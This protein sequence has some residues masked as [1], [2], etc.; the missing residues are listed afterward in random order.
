VEEGLELPEE[1]LIADYRGRRVEY[2]AMVEKEKE[3]TRL[4][5]EAERWKDPTKVLT[6]AQR[7]AIAEAELN[8][9]VRREEEEKLP[10]EK[11]AE[12]ARIRAIEEEN[13]NL[14]EESEKRATAEKAS[15]AQ[16]DREHTV[17]VY[18][19]TLKL[20]GVADSDKSGQPINSVEAQLVAAL[21]FNAKN[22]HGLEYPPETLAL[23]VRQQMAAASQ[24]YVTAGGA[25][26]LLSNPAVV[27]LLNSLNPTEHAGLLEQ[28]A[29]LVETMRAHNL[30]RRGLAAVPSA[31]QQGTPTVTGAVPVLTPGQEPRTTQEWVAYF[32]AGGSRE[33]RA[34]EVYWGLRDKGILQS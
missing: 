7:K 28:L 13:A 2:S 5:A 24:R 10:P 15:Q 6:P 4:R 21:M 22:Q 3:L 18:R 19:N 23:K 33:G 16:A 34:G 9:F 8:A 26:Q 30:Q 1:E 14:K 12:L 29:P 17:G 27:A 11:R 31:P 20:L 32:K 25:R